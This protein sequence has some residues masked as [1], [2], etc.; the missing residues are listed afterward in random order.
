LEIVVDDRERVVA[1]GL[2]TQRDLDVLGVGFRRLFPLTDGPDFSA[3][4]AAI[5]DADR[6]LQPESRARVQ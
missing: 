3:L 5:D 6:H 4:L 2:L 1:I